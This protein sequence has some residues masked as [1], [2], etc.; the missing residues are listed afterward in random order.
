MPWF[1]MSS[2]FTDNP[3]VVHISTSLFYR[4]CLTLGG[5]RSMVTFSLPMTS[6]FIM[7]TDIVIS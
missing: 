6:S 7:G 2:Y 5:Y 4:H 3:L 1:G